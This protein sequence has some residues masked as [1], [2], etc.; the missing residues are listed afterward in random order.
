MHPDFKTTNSW[1]GRLLLPV[2]GLLGILTAF[3]SAAAA[4]TKPASPP[5]GPAPAEVRTGVIPPEEWLRAPTNPLQPGEIDRLIARELQSS[6]ITP[7][8]LTTDEQFLRRVTLDLTGQLPVPADVTE[9]VADRDPRKRAKLIDKLLDSEEYAQHWARYWRDVIGSRQA[10]FRG[11][12]MVRHFEGWMAEQLRKNANWGDITRAMLTASGDV[13]FA[14][15]EKN[16]AAFFLAARFGAD[17]NVERAA[18]TSRIFLGIQIQCAQCHDHPSDVWKRQQFHEFAAYFA[19]LQSRPMRVNGQ[20]GG[21]QMV[22]RPFGEH[23]MPTK[24]DPRQGSVTMPRF[25][26]GEV[27]G[28]N[29]SDQQRRKALADSIVDKRN[30]WFAGAYVNRMWGELMGQSFYQPVD[31]LGPQKDAVFPGVLTR[32]AGAFRGSD[33]DT[34]A[35]LRAILNSQ[36]YQRQIRLGESSDEHLQ[37]AASYP[38]RLRA[39][40]LWESLVGVLGKMGGPPPTGPRP[41]PFAFLRNFEG[42]FKQEFR[43]DPSLRPD[44]VEG[45]ISQALLL[46]NNPV[47]NNR[48]QARG[49]NLLARILKAYPKDDDAIR[50]VYLRALA[51]KPTDREMAKVRAFLRKSGNRTEA[52]E[53]LLWA[54]INSTEFQTKR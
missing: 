36:T 14:E 31:D 11:L 27:P 20:L 33:Y 46:M 45:S 44:E 17:A 3:A 39:D 13:L 9:F 22:S 23:R 8:P 4:D 35:L 15:P 16:G 51:R 37:F 42:L 10:D 38:T 12:L 28:R 21:V 19:R 50:M 18:E 30:Y 26:N 48:I 25:L 6:K 24:A 2:L 41:M 7:A 47:I 34:K 49:T 53:D 54:L 52:F 40:A 1:R 32:L 43:F 29:L 5:K